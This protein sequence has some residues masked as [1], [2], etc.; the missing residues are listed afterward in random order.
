MRASELYDE[1][2][3]MYKV[4]GSL[5]GETPELGRANAFTRG[6]L[7]H[8]SIWLH[9]EYKYLLEMLKNGFY[10]DFF[11]D[12]ES[13]LIPFQPESRYGRSVLENCSF[14]AS[15][16]NPDPATHGRGFVARLSGATA[17]FLDIWQTMFFGAKPFDT[18]DG[19]LRLTLVP[20]LPK[21]LIPEDGAVS[22]MFLGRTMD[23]YQLPQRETVTPETH[24]AKAYHLTDEKGITRTVTGESLHEQDA[25]CVREGRVASIR[26]ELE[27]R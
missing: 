10:D 2:L 15:S 7:E 27:K 8:E 12:F 18:A 11:R 19:Q 9:M 6:W 4:S 23:T 17:E 26:V 5:S 25:L 13:A 1:E 3:K 22:A 14:L 21:R 20:A 16:A 24:R